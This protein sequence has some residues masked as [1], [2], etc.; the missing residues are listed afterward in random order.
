[1][2]GKQLAKSDDANEPS[3]VEAAAGIIGRK[4]DVISQYLPREVDD[5]DVVNAEVHRSII[6]R[7][8]GSAD[9]DSVLEVFESETIA[10]FEGRDIIIHEATF[11]DSEFEQGP[12]VYVS[13]MVE[14]VVAGTKHLINSGEQALMA[15]VIKF[16]AFESIPIRVSVWLAKRPN[17]FGRRLARFTKPAVTN[18]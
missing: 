16:Q 4:G 14:D 3:V 17:R 7:I 15:Q 18:G 2:P 6:E 8:L 5:P 11:R 10:N 13:L 12:P 9:L 1:M